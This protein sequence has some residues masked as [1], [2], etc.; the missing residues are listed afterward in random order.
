[1]VGADLDPKVVET[2]S[3]VVVL[4]GDRAYKLKKAVD[5]GFLDASTRQAREALCHREVALNRRLAPD[6]YLG[7]VDVLGTDGAPCDHA[8][9]MRRLPDDRRLAAMVVAGED[10]GSNLDAVA[11]L[12][13]GFHARAERGA[14]ADAAAGC[15]AMAARWSANTVEL[16]PYRGRYVDPDL[17][18]E[19]EVAAQRYLAGR[20]DLFAQRV[21]SGRACDGHGDLLA[22]DVFCLDDGPRLLD[23]LEFDDALRLGDGL[24]DAAFL[25]MDLEGRGRLDLAERFLDAYRVAA[26]DAWPASLAHHHVAYRAQVRAKVAAIR[27]AQ[28]DVP[29]PAPGHL[30]ELARDRLATAR[31]RL[32]LVGGLPGTGKSTLAA[33]LGPVLEAEVISSDAIRKELAGIPPGQPAAAGFGEGI[34]SAASTAATYRELLARAGRALRS[35][36]S[37]VLDASWGRRR[38]RDLAGTVAQE[39]A[40][41]LVELECRCPA[42]IATARMARRASRGGDPSDAD[43]RIAAA[44]A[45]ETDPWPTAVALDTTVQG[46]EVLTAASAAV[47]FGVRAGPAP[48]L[49]A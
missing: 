5:L 14:A 1:M 13:A 31:V 28:R 21:A 29:D 49:G 44:M 2:H 45:V 39:T 11:R 25:A 16:D 43:A 35:G 26:G 36:T 47:S 33:A 17:V 8:V 22:D 23:C 32:V 30:L 42:E 46:V 37:V 6:I 34:Y 12:L 48:R 3:G 41:D 9:V 27:A 10:V 18:D 4:L 24:A 19:V 15:D 40:S 20:H 38:W 7:V